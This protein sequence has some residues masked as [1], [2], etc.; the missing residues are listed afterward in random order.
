MERDGAV[1]A[2]SDRVVTEIKIMTGMIDCHFAENYR[3]AMRNFHAGRPLF[4]GQKAATIVP[5]PRY[6]LG[7]ITLRLD[8]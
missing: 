7:Y 3:I 4:E 8:V 2:R 6:P 5:D 1:E